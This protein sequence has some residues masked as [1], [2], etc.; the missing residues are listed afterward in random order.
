MKLEYKFVDLDLKYF[1]ENTNKY[2]G[3]LEDK[4]RKEFDIHCKYKNFFIFLNKKRKY[5]YI[6]NKDNDRTISLK[7]ITNNKEYL[8]QEYNCKFC[9]F[10]SNYLSKIILTRNKDNIYKYYLIQFNIYNYDI[11]I[12]LFRESEEILGIYNFAIFDKILYYLEQ[13]YDTNNSLLIKNDLNLSNIDIEANIKYFNNYYC[14]INNEIIYCF[15]NKEDYHD[16]TYYNIKTNEYILK[17]INRKKNTKLFICLNLGKQFIISI[18][19]IDNSIKYDKDVKDLY[20]YNIETDSMKKLKYNDFNKYKYLE[21]KDFIVY[22]KFNSNLC[23]FLNY[24]SSE[25][26]DRNNYKFKN[27]ELRK[28]IF[29]VNCCFSSKRKDENLPILSNDIILNIIYHMVYYII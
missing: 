2:L 12:K 25:W 18:L 6:Y 29:L 15:N 19:D 8:E 5:I 21:K 1:V 7:F 22:Y 4:D 9:K 16:I 13:Y 3:Y 28:L 17:K 11:K 24:E 23:K 26:N 14:K 10:Y 20:L 27:E